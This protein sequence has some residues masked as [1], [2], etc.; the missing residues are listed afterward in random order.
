MAT[1]SVTSETDDKHLHRRGEAGTKGWLLLSPHCLAVAGHTTG[2]GWSPAGAAGATVDGRPGTWFRPPPAAVPRGQ[3]A[4]RSRW[5]QPALVMTAEAATEGGPGGVEW[6]AASGT[7]A[8]ANRANRAS[9]DHPYGAVCSVLYIAANL[10]RVVV[11]TAAVRG[12]Q[13]RGGAFAT[14]PVSSS[15]ERIPLLLLRSNNYEYFCCLSS[16]AE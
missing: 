1:L 10:Q 5:E 2:E 16:G 6:D 4:R 13:K 3:G 14:F 15:S 8:V 11:E 9:R 12:Q 7:S